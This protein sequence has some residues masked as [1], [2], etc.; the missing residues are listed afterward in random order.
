MR[1]DQ[2]RYG[3]PPA[4]A[5]PLTMM[6][7]PARGGIGPPQPGPLLCFRCLVGSCAHRQSVRQSDV[8]DGISAITMHAGTALCLDCASAVTG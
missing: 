3:P 5:D 7:P 2:R 4:S 1:H 6:P 8:H